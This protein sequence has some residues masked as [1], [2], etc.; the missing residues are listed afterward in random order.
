[1]GRPGN[2]GTSGRVKASRE[3]RALLLAIANRWDRMQ[4]DSIE[5]G[6]LCGHTF[7][8]MAATVL[9]VE[10][11]HATTPL[12]LAGLL[13]QDDGNFGHDVGGILG[14]AEFDGTLSNHFWP[15]CGAAK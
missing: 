10:R 11:V 2:P 14:H 4:L 15:R 12:D 13:A 7:P 6:P 8:G 1:M 3:D 9:T 5:D